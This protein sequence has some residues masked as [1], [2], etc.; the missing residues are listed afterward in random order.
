MKNH[1]GG[2][3]MNKTLLKLFL[4]GWVFLSIGFF[5][6]S[7]YPS[8]YPHKDSG[9]VP[10]GWNVWSCWYFPYHDD[11]NPNLYDDGEA[12]N[13]YDEF[14]YRKSSLNPSSQAY[15]S[16]VH[17]MAQNPEPWWGHCH[18]WA[19]ASVWEAEP[20]QGRTL[21]G[22]HFRIRDRKGLAIESY[23]NCADGYTYDFMVDKPSP[24]LFW[25]YLRQEIKGVRKTPPM[26]GHAMGF[27]GELHYDWPGKPE[28]LTEIWNYPI[29][30]YKVVY[31]GTDTDVGNIL[32]GKMRIFV[33]NDS[34]PSLADSTKLS[35]ITFTYEFK[36]VLVS[37]GQ[38]TDSGY[39]IGDEND[40][41]SRPD[42]IWRPEYPKYWTTYVGNA[43]LEEHYLGK[44]LN[45]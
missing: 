1:H 30:A 10:A 15:E 32:D 39:W 41:K 14:V 9:Q 16:A 2:V 44:I 22:V 5:P 25:R 29:F 26:H 8:D 13:R 6:P 36:G 43:G 35:Y 18:A 34:E 23:F 37:N 31:E 3:T 28:E 45:P 33:A 21:K 27:V 11:Y 42:S 19:G 40:T 17:G 24:G 7:A 20:S 4:I 38:P 12:M